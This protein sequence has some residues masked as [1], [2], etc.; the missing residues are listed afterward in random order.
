MG[1]Q[2]AGLEAAVGTHNTQGAGCQA[3]EMKSTRVSMS[4]S[5]SMFW[6]HAQCCCQETQDSVFQRCLVVASLL[7]WLRMHHSARG[8]QHTHHH[9]PPPLQPEKYSNDLLN[10]KTCGSNKCT[11]SH[12]SSCFPVRGTWQFY[13][14]VSSFPP[15]Q[16]RSDFPDWGTW[17]RCLRMWAQS[18]P[19]PSSFGNSLSQR[20]CILVSLIPLYC[21]FPWEDSFIGDFWLSSAAVDT[22]NFGM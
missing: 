14:S 13:I 1:Q 16:R 6:V 3:T 9:F 10:S 21:S 11:L 12:Y 20:P 7:S 5:C 17:E 8:T 19:L 15:L 22:L 4:H 18:P 2:D